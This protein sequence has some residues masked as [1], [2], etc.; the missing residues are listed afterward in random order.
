[1]SRDV[2]RL[3]EAVGYRFRNRKLLL[4]ALTHRSFP[5]GPHNERLEFLGDAVFAIS[6]AD[7]LFRDE[8]ALSESLMSKIKSAVVSGAVLSETA[9][10]ISLGPH[11][12][13]G[14]C[15]REVGGEIKSSILTGSMEA[16]IGA[17][18][19]DGG[20]EEAKGLVLRLFG[21]RLLAL[22]RSGEVEDH[23]TAL[24]EL[25]QRRFGIL[26]DYRIIKEEGAEH[27][28]LFTAEVFISGSRMGMGSGKSKK[29]AET[30]AA[31]EALR[32]ILSTE[33]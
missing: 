10:D 2:G 15:E 26:P 3:E 32:Q 7:F 6:A 23:K 31:K 33:K 17:V 9:K 1:M 28:K 8:G 16:V 14:K 27:K 21:K 20:F 13:L 29:E 5:E 18:Y 4:E 30:Q 24:Q 22:I 25:T 11:I 12:R 19:M